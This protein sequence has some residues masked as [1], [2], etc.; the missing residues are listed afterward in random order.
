M[1]EEFQRFGGLHNR[2]QKAPDDEGKFSRYESLYPPVNATPKPPD[3]GTHLSR[4]DDIAILPDL[5]HLQSE[6]MREIKMV[7]RSFWRTQA[8]APCED[9]RFRGPPTEETRAQGFQA[10]ELAGRRSR[11]ERTEGRLGKDCTQVERAIRMRDDL[12]KAAFTDYGLEPPKPRTELVA[13]HGD[14]VNVVKWMLKLTRPGP[15]P[16]EQPE[17]G[18]P[19]DNVEGGPQL[20]WT[21]KPSL[22]VGPLSRPQ[23]T[24]TQG[25]AGGQVTVMAKCS[26]S[27][28]LRPFN[29]SPRRCQTGPLHQ[30]VLHNCRR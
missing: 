1:G 13:K 27:R 19:S 4:Q 9:K 23:S 25:R 29:S 8:R 2:P 17:T 15:A 20:I 14:T 28:W 11:W 10:E 16:T 18:Q 26:M 5:K 22:G 21:R 6:E 24:S 7:L 3:Q 12:W 30:T